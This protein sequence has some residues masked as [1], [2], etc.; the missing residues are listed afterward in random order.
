MTSNNQRGSMT[1]PDRASDEYPSMQLVV[2]CTLTVV[3]APS[4]MANICAVIE[5]VMTDVDSIEWKKETQVLV[6]HGHTTKPL[7][8]VT[9]KLYSDNATSSRVR[10]VSYH[11]YRAR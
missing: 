9:A 6:A 8:Y 3:N 11:Q 10:D 1:F 4:T 2:V 7:S 5:D